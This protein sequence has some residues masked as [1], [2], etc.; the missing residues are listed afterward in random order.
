MC[1][2]PW[3]QALQEELQGRRRQQVSSLQEISSQLLLD[4]AG[5]DGVEAA[6]KVHVASN[7]LRLLL[8]QVNADLPALRQRLVPNTRRSTSVA[9]SG[10]TGGSVCFRRAAA[11]QRNQPDPGTATAARRFSIRYSRRTQTGAGSRSLSNGDGWVVSGSCWSPGGR[12][13]TGSAQ[14]VNSGLFFS[15]PKARRRGYHQ[16]K[17]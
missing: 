16:V 13:W 7:R 15:K 12:G 8:R 4:A 5:D 11:A 10:A 1:V 9:S 3:W 6:E 17:D 2:A 14:K